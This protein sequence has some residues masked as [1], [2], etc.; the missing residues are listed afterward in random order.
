M[1]YS[2]A[3]TKSDPIVITIGNFDG[4]HKGHQVLMREVCLLAAQFNSQP[5][6]LTF[7]PHALKIVRPEINLL[8]LT[9]LEE[10]IALARVYGGI[11]NAIVLT[12]TPAVAAMSA[13][14]FLD[15]LRTR[16]NLRGLVVGTNF[17]LGHNRLGNVAFIQEYGRTHGIEI[18]AIP[19]EGMG[20]QRI[21]ST[22]IRGLVSAGEVE[23]AR[24]LL[25]HPLIFSGDVVQGDQRGRLLGFPTANLVLPPDKLLPANGVYAAKVMIKKEQAVSDAIHSSGVYI[26]AKMNKTGGQWETYKSATNIG[27][28]P[29]FAGQTRLV[30]AHLLD[31]E[32]LNLYNRRMNI[33]LIARLRSEQRFANIEALKTQIAEDVNNARSILQRD[34]DLE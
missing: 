15:D 23:E 20:E 17:S 1:E 25:G 30:E 31:V 11:E 9:T 29:T 5:A 6:F 18:R 22:Y 26:D 13:T 3:L 19:L 7:Q 33:H 28:R 4:I 12:F 21:T 34:G 32:G 24:R 16:F 8:C 14:E 10:K 27:I 2:T